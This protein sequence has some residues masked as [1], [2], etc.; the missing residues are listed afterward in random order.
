VALYSSQTRDK[1][2]NGGLK[3]NQ[4]HVEYY[5][6]FKACVSLICRLYFYNAKILIALGLFVFTGVCWLPVVWLQIKM[7]ELAKQSL[8]TGDLLCENPIYKRYI[9]IW[10]SL[11]WPAFS[12]V[13]VIFYLMVFKPNY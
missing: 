10:F 12:A 13:I 6:I 7:H 8:K 1:K 11:G 4:C 9:K 3:R 2:K 5:K